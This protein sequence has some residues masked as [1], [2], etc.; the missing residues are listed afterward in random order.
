MRALNDPNA[1]RI[2]DVD[3]RTYQERLAEQLGIPVEHLQNLILSDDVSGDFIKVH[4]SKWPF[5]VHQRVSRIALAPYLSRDEIEFTNSWQEF[6][7]SD[8]YQDSAA[9]FIH[10]MTGRTPDPNDTRWSSD[11]PNVGGALGAGRRAIEIA[12][13]MSATDPF[14]PDKIGE[15]MSRDDARTLSNAWISANFEF[16]Q[17]ALDEGNRTVALMHFAF[18]LHTLQDST[19]PTHFGF[20]EW[21]EPGLF[22]KFLHGSRE[23]FD[24]GPQSDLHRATR[25]MHRWFFQERKLPA[26][27]LFQYR[28]YQPPQPPRFYPAPGDF[29]K[30]QAA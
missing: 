7:D 1:V 5:D 23:L 3:N 22:D 16:A 18:A 9:S 11:D 6:I 27:D 30:M 28:P 20:Q 2:S 17:K 13:S 15:V 25:D 14:V 4:A 26:G 29:S 10:A 21:T 12:R 24:P 19:S 8:L